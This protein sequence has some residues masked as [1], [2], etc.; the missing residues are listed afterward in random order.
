[1]GHNLIDGDSGKHDD[2][3][4]KQKTLSTMAEVKVY[5]TK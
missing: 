1:M 4:T 5:A 2:D 3:D